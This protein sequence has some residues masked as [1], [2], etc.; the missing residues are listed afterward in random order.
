MLTANPMKGR[1]GVARYE[2]DGEKER[3]I[4]RVVPKVYAA[5]IN[6]LLNYIQ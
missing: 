2:A 5:H 6:F 1:C 4:T 3:R